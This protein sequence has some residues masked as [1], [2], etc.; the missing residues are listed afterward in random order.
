MGRGG[1]RRGGTQFAKRGGLAGERSRLWVLGW[2]SGAMV[3]KGPLTLANPRLSGVA[4]RSLD[5]AAS[6]PSEPTLGPTFGP[7]LG[8]TLELFI[9]R[10][11]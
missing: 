2:G 5:G 1:M 10:R 6:L 7:T 3:F 8:P 11:A 9:T 4:G